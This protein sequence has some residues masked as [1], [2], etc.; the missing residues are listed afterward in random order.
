MLFLLRP[1]QSRMPSPSPRDPRQQETWNHE[2][3]DAYNGTMRVEASDGAPTL[4]GT[5]G[6]GA[7][8]SGLPDKLKELGELHRSG[9]LT[10]DEFASAKATLL[11]PPG[12]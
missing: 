7:P 12:G 4:P 5:S 9:A 1:P 3:E 10:D 2:L 6:P 8:D 11:V